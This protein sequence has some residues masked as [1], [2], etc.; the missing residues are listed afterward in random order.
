MPSFLRG[1]QRTKVLQIARAE[2]RIFIVQADC[3]Q[4]TADFLKLVGIETMCCWRV[5]CLQRA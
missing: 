5:L 2:L 3:M 4:K 1:N